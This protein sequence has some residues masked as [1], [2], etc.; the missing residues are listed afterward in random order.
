MGRRAAELPRARARLA[1]GLFAAAL[2]LVAGACGEGP[3]P[4]ELAGEGEP[5][6]HLPVVR[7]AAGVL[8][9]VG[10]VF[11]TKDGRVSS[12]VLPALRVQPEGEAWLV[13]ASFAALS[14]S[15]PGFDPARAVELGA[16]AARPP[17]APERHLSPAGA[18]LLTRLPPEARVARV[19]AGGA[20][21]PLEPNDPARAAL[22]EA[23]TLAVPEDPEHCRAPGPRP[24]VPYAGVRNAVAT[25]EALEPALAWLR[26]VVRVDGARL[27]A[28]GPFALYLVQRGRAVPHAGPGEPLQ[29][30]YLGDLVPE[31]EHAAIIALALDP[32]VAEDGSRHLLVVGNH[33]HPTQ[34]LPLSGWA[35]D[36]RV[37]PNGFAGAETATI[38][39]GLVH[40]GAAIDAA[41]RQVI[42]ADGS[43]LL[44]RD[45][46]GPWRRVQLPPVLRSDDEG[47]RAVATGDPTHSLLVGTR[48]RMHLYDA[49]RALWSTEVIAS[50]QDDFQPY[51]VAAAPIGGVLE[52]W[53]GSSR[54]R[55]VRRSPSGWQSVELA[56]PPR[57][58]PCQTFGTPARPD[59]L[60]R[61]EA[62]AMAGGYAY[63]V[64][65]RCAALVV[66]RLEDRC[67]SLLG[68]EGEGVRA[69]V[70]GFQ[71]LAVGGGELVVVGDDGQIWF[72]PLDAQSP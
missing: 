19:G 51:A 68:I 52:Q 27:V 33:L 40:R 3:A 72:T 60:R 29:H 2:A 17:A 54:G 11:V 57:F 45:R 5:R 39:T 15:L 56:P 4:V 61:V 49:A 70:P 48:A 67:V 20:S 69:A 18:T 62:M 24:L 25:F 64:P 36:V 47:R 50:E 59:F 34:S 53:A 12:G 55:V 23:I 43:V 58:Y 7:D 6:L 44:M 30:H 31:P 66:V 10:P 26:H 41:G 38:A 32:E 14:A 35:V 1:S 9:Q 16:S 22:L 65:D 71:D 28:A 8:T 37:G 42:V 63:L 13:S 46:G 21:A